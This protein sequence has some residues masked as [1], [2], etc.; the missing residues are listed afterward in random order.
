MLLFFYRFP[1]PRPPWW[2]PPRC[3]ASPTPGRSLG[4][5]TNDT[6]SQAAAARGTAPPTAW[7][8]NSNIYF[9]KKCL[10][11]E[12]SLILD[13]C[14]RNRYVHR[15]K[16]VR[17]C[18]WK[19]ALM[20]PM[21]PLFYYTF[22]G[23]RPPQPPY[24]Y[25]RAIATFTTDRP[26]LV[27]GLNCPLPSPP[28]PWRRPPPS[29]LDPLPYIVCSKFRIW[30]CNGVSHTGLMKYVPGRRGEEGIAGT[31]LTFGAGGDERWGLFRSKDYHRDQGPLSKNR[32]GRFT[33]N[34]ALP[35]EYTLSRE[36]K[37]FFLTK[38]FCKKSI[39]QRNV[40]KWSIY[41][42]FVGPPAS[43]SAVPP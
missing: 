17:S 11:W 23:V 36:S 38:N 34:L 10:L 24:F 15:I 32:I 7:Q 29:S 27:I 22:E 40:S 1:L 6:D 42:L 8:G 20:P 26:P 43:P 5:L 30:R 2:S 39:S 4:K 33:I 16:G 13:L 37:S 35:K 21:P 19:L 25:P 18:K 12:C 14:I 3:S 9:F 41:Y 31:D 28:L